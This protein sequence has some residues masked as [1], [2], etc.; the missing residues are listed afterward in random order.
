MSMNKIAGKRDEKPT[1]NS[2]TPAQSSRTQVKE[3]IH[4]V[5]VTEHC[6]VAIVENPPTKQII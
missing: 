4:L 1:K 6:T 2:T 5:N 3:P